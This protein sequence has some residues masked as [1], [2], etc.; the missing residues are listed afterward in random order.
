MELRF[1]LHD[2]CANKTNNRVSGPGELSESCQSSD[3]CVT[4]LRFYIKKVDD[5]SI[6]FSA[7]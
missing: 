7:L 2:L 5:K 6:R 4:A 1:E 3:E